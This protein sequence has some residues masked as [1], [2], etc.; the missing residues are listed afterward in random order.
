MAMR[1]IRSFL[2]TG[3]AVMA[4]GAV[5]AVQASVAASVAANVAANVTAGQPPVNR[6]AALFKEFNDRVQNYVK[7]HKQRESALPALQKRTTAA[8][9]E[10]H[11]KALAAAIRMARKDAM[12]GDIFFQEVRPEFLKILSSELKGPG[13]ATARAAIK[14]TKPERIRLRVNALYPEEASLSMVPPMVLL[15]L[16][17]LPEE[18]EYRFV[19]HHLVLRDKKANLIVDYMVLPGVLV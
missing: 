7:V 13:S 19:N 9:I 15:N 6:T 11:K 18:L 12:P 3:L 1:S 16:P 4:A 8:Q 2:K 10:A 17:T 14:E 5:L